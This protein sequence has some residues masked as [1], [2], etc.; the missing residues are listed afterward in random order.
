MFRP[1]TVEDLSNWVKEQSAVHFV[2]TREQPCNL[3]LAGLTS[4]MRIEKSDFFG[5]FSAGIPFEVAAKELEKLGLGFPFL[6]VDR[7][8]TLGDLVNSGMPNIWS[9]PLG[10][11][12]YSVMAIQFMLADGSVAKSGANV[13]KSV[14][15]FDLHKFIVGAMGTVAIPLEITFQLVPLQVVPD[16]N[17]AQVPNSTWVQR[18]LPADYELASQNSPLFTN[19]EFQTIWFANR[20]SRR[21]DGDW[22]RRLDGRAGDP[23]SNPKIFDRIKQVFDPSHKL[24]PGILE[25]V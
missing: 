25:A 12:P 3:D 15:G 16:R 5:C 17:V 8:L 1:Q 2:P 18:V 13:A 23:L 4:P 22:I 6:P 14:A 20:P 19:P 7:S 9:T 21:F 10:E 11:W 24:S